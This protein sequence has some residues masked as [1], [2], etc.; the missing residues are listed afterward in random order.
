MAKI[1]PEY[2]KRLEEENA[3]LK[4]A[5]RILKERGVEVPE[6]A[7]E[8]PKGRLDYYGLEKV[9]SKAKRVVFRACLQLTRLG[10]NVFTPEDVLRQVRKFDRTV[11]TYTVDRALR[12]LADQNEYF[13]APPPLKRVGEGQ[14]MLNPELSWETA[15]AKPKTLDSFFSHV[16]Q[17]ETE[18]GRG[19]QATCIR[20][21]VG[22]GRLAGV[23][24]AASPSPK[25]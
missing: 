6:W 18:R 15:E 20:S 21:G 25:T 12:A 22:E 17:T 4:A 1:D 16:C 11:S 7:L 13:P 14:Y 10:V 19:R 9:K 23:K 2:V 24:A 8:P 3:R 5:L